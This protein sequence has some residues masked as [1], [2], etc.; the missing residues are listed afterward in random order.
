MTAPLL[1]AK[2]AGKLLNVPAGWVLAE[3][4]ANRIPHLRLGKY[5]RF[6]PD[7]LEEWWTARLQGPVPRHYAGGEPT[8]AGRRRANA[9]THGPQETG[10]P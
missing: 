2:Q 7:V 8:K 10:L 3:A 4:R 1:D 9:P 6:V 5:V